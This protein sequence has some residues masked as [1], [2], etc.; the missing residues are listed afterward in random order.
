[1][2]RHLAIVALVAIGAYG[3]T[4]NQNQQC[5]CPT[6]ACPAPKTT[7]AAKPAAAAE[8]PATPAQANIPTKANPVTTVQ[9]TGVETPAA[10]T[11]TAVPTKAITPVAPAQSTVEITSIQAVVVA[12]APPIDGTLNSPIWEKSP[13]LKFVNAKDNQN[14]HLDT[15]ARVLVDDNNLYVA[16]ACAEAKTDSL[17][18]SAATGTDDIWRDDSVEVYISADGKTTYHYAV[19]AKGAFS[20]AKVTEDEMVDNAWKSDAVIKTTLDK[21]KGWSVTLCIPLKSFAAKPGDNQTWLFN[22]NR[23]KPN[24]DDTSDWSETTWSTRGTSKYRDMS[25]WGRLTGVKV[26]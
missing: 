2:K 5:S 12:E 15:T 26:K 3:C 10:Q 13:A 20:A 18:A 4:S 24:G 17:V 1:M 21:G 9:P 6:T 16:F 19:N 7:P 11:V 22:L 23:T 14:A 8:T 25:T